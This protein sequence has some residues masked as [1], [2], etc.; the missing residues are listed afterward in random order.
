MCA[1]FKWGDLNL[2]DRN[3]VPAMTGTISPPF[4]LSLCCCFAYYEHVFSLHTNAS[5]SITW[6]FACFFTYT[7]AALKYSTF[8]LCSTRLTTDSVKCMMLV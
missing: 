1:A 3:N 4:S 7:Y 6:F 5:V 2:N 8:T